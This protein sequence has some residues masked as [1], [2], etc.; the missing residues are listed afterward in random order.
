MIVIVPG[1]EEAWPFR[2]AL[3][4]CTL[5]ARLSQGVLASVGSVVQV[6]HAAAYHP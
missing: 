1:P 3:A 6:Q 5:L 4:R 2:S